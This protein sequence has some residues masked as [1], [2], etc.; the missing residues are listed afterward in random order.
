M[1][2]QDMNSRDGFVY[3]ARLYYGMSFLYPHLHRSAEIIH[4]IKG[5]ILV[6]INAVRTHVPAGKCV[7]ILPYRLHSFECAPDALFMVHVFSHDC[8]PEFFRLLGSRTSQSP[9]FDAPEENIAYYLKKFGVDKINHSEHSFEMLPLAHTDQFVEFHPKV[10]THN[11][12]LPQDVRLNLITALESVLAGFLA[13]PDL[14]E[15]GGGSLIERVL[16]YIGAHSDKDLTLETVAAELGYEPH[17][18]CRRMKRYTDI[19]FRTLVNSFRVEHAKELLS[20]TSMQTTAIAEIC[21]FGS[22]RTFNRVF[23]QFTK[24]PPSEYRNR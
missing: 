5:E 3:D 15:G 4:V 10:V 20:G 21:G 1:I 23:R 14:A 13:K 22:L 9:V 11:P 12:V 7:L 8:A 17:Y 18:L 19:G 24:I 6:D 2:N 16:S